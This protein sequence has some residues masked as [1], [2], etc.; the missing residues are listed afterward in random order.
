MVQ[1]QKAGTAIGGQG[2]RYAV[3]KQTWNGAWVQSLQQLLDNQSGQHKKC[4]SSFEY[5]DIFIF[6]CL[7]LEK[8]WDYTNIPGKVKIAVLF[9]G[10]SVSSLWNKLNRIYISK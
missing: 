3:H 1:Q 10:P 9:L 4:N 6:S 8:N 2:A 7:R 5:I